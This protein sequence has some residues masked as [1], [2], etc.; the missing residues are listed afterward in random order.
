MVSCGVQLENNNQLV[1]EKKVYS[2]YLYYR[3]KA[4]ECTSEDINLELTKDDQVYLAVF[5]IPLKSGIIGSQ[6]ESLALVFGLS[7]HIYCG[8]GCA[9]TGLECNPEIKKAS[10]SLMI[11]IPQILNKM[12]LIS[13][14]EFYNSE[15]IRLYLKTRKGIYFRELAGEV[16]E[17]RFAEMLLRR[18]I[19]EINRVIK[20]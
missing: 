1:K 7:T 16:K 19:N 17:D 5:D 18:V 9:V 3:E 8:N 2:R 14:T 15:N 11:S 6:T 13:D 20:K 10:D 12:Q 4:L